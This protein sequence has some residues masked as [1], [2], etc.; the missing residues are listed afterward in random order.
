MRRY[1]AGDVRLCVGPSAHAV[2]VALPKAEEHYTRVAFLLER[3]APDRVV[4]IR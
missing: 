2:V 1:R 3:Y 4:W